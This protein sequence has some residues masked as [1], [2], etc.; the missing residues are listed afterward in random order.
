[1]GS[2]M[3]KI[4]AGQH[5]K[6]FINLLLLL[7]CLGIVLG[8][9]VPW[10]EEQKF[11]CCV[12]LGVCLAGG[13]IL[14]RKNSPYTALLLLAAIV[15][16]GLIRYAGATAMPDNDVSLLEGS[17]VKLEGIIADTPRISHDA[18]GRVKIRYTVQ[19]EAVTEKGERR[20]AAG[21]L[22]VYAN[23][24]S[25]DNKELYALEDGENSMVYGGHDTAGGAA[26]ADGDKAAGLSEAELFGRSGDGIV[27]TGTVQKIH[28]YGN[29]G[30]LNIQM[31]NLAQG[32]TAQLRPDK[33]SVK[34]LPQEADTVTR[35]T[36]KV[37]AY[38]RSSMERVMSAQDSAAIFAMLFGGYN[39]IKEDLIDVFTS[40]GLIHILSVSGSHITLMAGT[41]GVLGKA[42]H[43]PP[44]ATAGLSVVTII[45]YGLLAGGI[46]P[47]IRSVIMGLLTVLALTMGREK[48]AQYILGLTALGM[49]LYSPLLLYD[50]SFQLSF[51]ATAGLLYL[52]PP[53]RVLLRKK[54]PVFAADSLAVTIGAQLSVLPVIAWYFNAIYL[55]SLAANLVI[56]PIIEWII[57]AGLLAGLII[58]FVPLLGEIIFVLAGLVLGLAY[59]MSRILADVPGSKVYV[60]SFGWCS[61]CVYY[62]LLG[63]F[64]LPEE[65]R[66]AVFSAVGL[67]VRTNWEKLAG[68]YAG[69][70]RGKRYIF[71][72]GTGT[73]GI[74]ILWGAYCWPS[75]EM[76]VHFID[77]GQGDG[78]LV[79]T[80]HGHAFMVDTGGTREGSY[81]I[82][83]MVDVPYLLHYGVRQLDAIFLTHAHDDHAAGVRGILGRLPVNAI[84]IGHEGA[85]DYL[86]VFGTGDNKKLEKLL[87]PLQENTTMMLDGVKIEILYSPEA[88]AVQESN[89]AATGNEFSNL[90]R[91]SYGRASFLF[92]G[93]LVAEQ[94]AELLRRGTPLEST[95]LKVGH[96]GSRSSSSEKFL[97][98]VKPRWAVISCGYRNSFGHP[99]KEILQRLEK[100]MKAKIL[101]TD[102]QGA[103]C[104]RTDGETMRVECFR[105]G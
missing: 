64:L 62:M 26:A 94:E 42:L 95:V 5:P 85:A 4:K 27:L 82:G 77:V 34:I 18:A 47:V 78:A 91:V 92:T 70:K 17:S 60:P 74:M 33:Y 14:A 55:S 31:S 40:V 19:A 16:L 69:G 25:L 8:N 11:F 39:G 57:V 1:M 99:H 67:W 90:I 75:R 45:F 63:V 73:V 21:K 30:R 13:F 68:K 79:I 86:K 9:E 102:T 54:L 71:L 29:P 66:L 6:T 32:I 105:E 23:A 53:L 80:P 61:C 89:I 44:K 36:A 46:P 59:E 7:F 50:I 56:A 15:L 65:K 3:V 35:L 24:T 83:K 87:S 104:F 97:E 10:L 96:H 98:A 2:Y 84:M 103:I 37:R 100:D 76:Q 43:L 58:S 28:D 20:G 81:D 101:R 52:G 38:Y 93:D 51:G 72:L 49:L 88:K 12:L 48:D 41:A 22:L